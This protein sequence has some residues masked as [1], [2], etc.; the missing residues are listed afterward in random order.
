MNKKYYFQLLI[1]LF[2]ILPQIIYCQSKYEGIHSLQKI[3]KFSAPIGIEQAKG[4]FINGFQLGDKNTFV[5]YQSYTDKTGVSHK[6]YQQYYNGIKVEYG[7]MIIHSKAGQVKS[8]NGELYNPK[9]LNLSSSLSSQ[10]GLESAKNHV[11]AKRYLWNDKEASKKMKYQ[12][13]KG[14]LIIFPVIGNSSLELK[15]AYKYDIYATVPVS[16]GNIYIDAHNGSFLFNDVIIKHYKSIDEADVTNKPVA[17]RKTNKKASLVTSVTSA[18]TGDTRY[19]GNRSIE[20]RAE[21]NGTYTL[22]DDIRNIHTYN[23]QNADSNSNSYFFTS[24]DFV[25][26]DNNW[27][28]AE[29]DNVAKDNAALDVHWGTMQVYD[30]WASLGRDSYNDSG[31]EIRSYVHLGTDYFNAFWNGSVMSYGDGSPN[32]L[33]SIDVV[34]HEIAHAVTATTANLVYARESGG[35]NEGFSD[36]FG[37]AIEFFAKGTGTD[38]NP[39]AE[40]WLIGE[41]FGMVLR[42]MSNPK[43]KGDPDTYN[44]NNYV[45]ATASCIPEFGP[46]GNDGCGV[47]TNSGVLNHWFYILVAGKAGQNDAGDNYNVTGI[48]MVKSQEIAYLTLRDYL[49]PNATFMDARNGAIEVASNLYGSNSDERQATQDA[50]YAVNVGDA[51]IPYDTDL[52]VIEFSEL[53]DITCGEDVIAK[54]RVRNTGAT[55]TINTIQVNYSIDGAVQTPFN[56]NGVLAID[57]ETEITLPAINKI[58]ITSYD[59]TVNMVVAGDGDATN[60]TLTGD[61]RINRGDNMPTTV[62][63]FESILNDFWLNYNEGGGTNLWVIGA[64]NK[65]SL[66]AVTSG[67]KAYVTALT[68]DYPNNTKAYL[69]S[70][71]YDLSAL[72]NPLLKFNMA[73]KLQENF[74]ILYVEYATATEN[75]TLLGSATD[76][77]WYNSDRFF[78]SSEI[79][80]DCQNCPGAQWT[81]TSSAFTEYSYDLSSFTNES[82]IKFRFV[83]HSNTTGTDEGVVIDDFV[84]EAS[85]LSVDDIN[86]KLIS[87]YPNP[88]F[89]V[90]VL[91]LKNSYEKIDIDI[92]DVTGKIVLRKKRISI[93]DNKYLLDMT[94]YS[95]GLYFARIKTEEIITL[96]KLVLQ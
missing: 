86:S 13:P 4:R 65:T 30:F 22:N 46:G 79:S 67:S 41:D 25:D 78:E 93:A 62:N 33:T 45:N 10:V 27:T 23:A 11:G 49:S 34:G 55:N 66:N 12:K 53:V 3:M 29:H 32:P 47:H 6:K 94:G 38:S 1:I 31:A 60:D 36:I 56:W 37:S 84:I 39:N 76:L 17:H 82:N 58:G 59:L 50:F 63:P 42:S 20:T 57:A 85:S 90:F 73:F 15:L 96:K 81:G 5:E 87:I 9:G 68:S 77:N 54:I 75:W 95:K 83:F 26:D 8:I 72:N 21:T 69:I 2:L 70:P 91:S 52:N 51:F 64:P 19:S 48:G 28:L 7:T 18:G 14:R 88:S 61:F 35:M 44:G 24:V 43:S 74:D 40:T 80:N 16:R 71:C 89:G 92:I